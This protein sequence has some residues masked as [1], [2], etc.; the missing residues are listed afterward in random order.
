MTDTA[1]LILQ[2]PLHPQRLR[3]L[4]KS[5]QLSTE[6]HNYHLQLIPPSP[7]PLISS[8]PSTTL[9]MFRNSVGI[10][11]SLGNLFPIY[12]EFLLK[13]SEARWKIQDFP[14]DIESG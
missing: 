11:N 1:E 9:H 8:L 10:P 7:R 3:F 4:R 14:V 2:A 5:Q 12:L 6:F 13:N